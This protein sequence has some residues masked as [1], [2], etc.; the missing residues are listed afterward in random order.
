MLNKKNHGALC[1]NK[2]IAVIEIRYLI[3]CN[4]LETPLKLLQHMDI[5]CFQHPPMDHKPYS[6]QCIF[7]FLRIKARAE[8]I[9]RKY[10]S[11]F[12]VNSIVLPLSFVALTAT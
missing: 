9:K 7:D 10:I 3:Q 1:I 4:F 11:Y 8:T 5:Y 2:S 6:L 12:N